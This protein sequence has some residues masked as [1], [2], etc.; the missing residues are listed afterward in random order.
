LR[1]RAVEKGLE[2]RINERMIENVRT[3]GNPF[4]EEVKDGE[5]P[6]ELYCC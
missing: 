1:K 4:G 6:K 5:I 3:M 2:T